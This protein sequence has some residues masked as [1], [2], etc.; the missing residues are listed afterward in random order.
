MKHNSSKSSLQQGVDPL[1]F[2]NL[3]FLIGQIRVRWENAHVLVVLI[4]I[5]SNVR[6]LVYGML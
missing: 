2:M 5:D 6:G 1:P 3:K 4:K